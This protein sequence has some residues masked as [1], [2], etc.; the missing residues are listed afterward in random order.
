VTY[1]V[2]E[3]A[4]TEM[5][6]AVYLPFGDHITLT[7]YTLNDD[8]FVP[9]DIVQVTLF[10]QTA[11]PLDRRYKVFIH[12]VD[13]SGQPIA[14]RDS[15]PGGGLNLTTVWQPGEVIRDNHGLLIPADVP[16]GQYSI[17][18]GLYD[19]AD[20]MARLPIT[21]NQGIVEAISLVTFRLRG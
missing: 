15:E 6:T 3:E 7:G 9:G 1:A 10:W 2:P 11:E 12:L 8:Q 13:A 20:P 14:Q 16:P 5:A 18:L 4:A 19:I 17:L 21:T